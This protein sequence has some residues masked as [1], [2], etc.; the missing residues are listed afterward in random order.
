KDIQKHL[1]QAFSVLGIPKEIK[2]HNGPAYASTAFKG[3]L[4][5]WGIKHKTGIPYSPT[6]QGMAEHAHQM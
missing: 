1:L 3:F 6:G 4:Q 2:L 5:K